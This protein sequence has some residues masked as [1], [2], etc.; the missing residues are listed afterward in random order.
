M[1][2][3]SALLLA[4]ILFI[5]CASPKL[6]SYKSEANDIAAIELDF[7]KNKKFK[8]HFRD[9]EEKPRKNYVFKG[10][11]TD[12]MDLYQLNFK[13]DSRGLPDINALFDPALSSVKT[14]RILNP[15]M[16]EFK[17]SLK[18]IYIWGL[19]CIKRGAEKK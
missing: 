3:R 6:L 12:K 13:L 16:V 9:L 18:V 4:F 1:V 8:L 5:S 2:F 7:H 10:H 14:V 17:K 11:W 15:K 19:P